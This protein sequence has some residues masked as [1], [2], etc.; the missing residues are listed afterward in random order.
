MTIQ[1]VRGRFSSRLPTRN[2]I[3]L[4]LISAAVGA[5][6]GVTAANG[7]PFE[8]SDSARG[9]AVHS[10]VASP[11]G[12]TGRDS[13]TGVRKLSPTGRQGLV[14]LDPEVLYP[15]ATSQDRKFSPTGRQGVVDSDP[16]VLYQNR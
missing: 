15:N 7:N 1:Y 8:D 16:G 2:Q 12:A 10:P 14:D 13:S 4:S 6:I 11:N 5:V 3:A 9:P